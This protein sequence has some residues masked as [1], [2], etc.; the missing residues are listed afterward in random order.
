MSNRCMNERLAGYSPHRIL[1]K[2]RGAHTHRPDD[3]SCIECADGLQHR[4]DQLQKSRENPAVET[5]FRNCV[6]RE[7]FSCT[8]L[9]QLIGATQ[10]R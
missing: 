5:Y 9:C 6:T 4:H 2:R 7:A 10:G 3:V 1:R 8:K